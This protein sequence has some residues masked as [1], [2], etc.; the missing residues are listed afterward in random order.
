MPTTN[1]YNIQD[2]VESWEDLVGQYTEQEIVGMC[3][4]YLKG[5]ERS[6][7]TRATQ[8]AELKQFRAAKKAGL[9]NQSS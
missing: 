3:N 1:K 5:R 6:K 2:Q 4:A 7:H 8:Q 9:L